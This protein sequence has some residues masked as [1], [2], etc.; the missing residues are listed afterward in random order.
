MKKPQH[1]RNPQ[2]LKKRH[3]RNPQFLKKRHPRNPQFLKKRRL[4]NP[5]FL[6]KQ[7]LR[8]L[9]IRAQMKPQR[10]IRMLTTAVSCLSS[11]L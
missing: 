7:H 10:K 6:R 8:S 3:P 9:L 5:Q 1:L 4:R 11:L 2:F